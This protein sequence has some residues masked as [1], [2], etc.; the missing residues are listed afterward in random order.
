VI[1]VS[2]LADFD[3]KPGGLA[4]NPS[5]LSCPGLDDEFAEFSNFGPDVDVVA[6]GVCISST[7]IRGGYAELTG[8]SQAAAHAA[9]AAALYLAAHPDATPAQV[10]SALVAAGSL[11]WLAQTDPDGRP[12]P[13]LDVAGF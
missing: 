13:L 1:T 9:G 10:R 8:T 5:P 2:A 6:P 12:D 3:G 7:W 4:E 11:K